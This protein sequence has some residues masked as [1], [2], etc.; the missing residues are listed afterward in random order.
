MQCLHYLLL[1]SLTSVAS[2]TTKL[3]HFFALKTTHMI[4][5]VTSFLL[6]TCSMDVYLIDGTSS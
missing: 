2:S 5:S 6:L 1:R 4:S 3:S